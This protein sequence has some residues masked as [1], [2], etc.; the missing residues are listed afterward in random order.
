MH[1][2]CK[3][4][5]EV[6]DE[7]KMRRKGPFL[8]FLQLFFPHFFF[9]LLFSHIH[10]MSVQLNRRPALLVVVCFISF[11]I[12]SHF[13]TTPSSSGI[14]VSDHHHASLDL[15]SS[16]HKEVGGHGERF[17]SQKYHCIEYIYIVH[18]CRAAS[19]SMCLCHEDLQR[20]QQSLL[21]V[22]LLL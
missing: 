5:G 10:V 11:A 12:L 8:G 19:G 17:I 21:G 4:R 3:K 7:R 2:I 16:H 9:H 1:A 20:I 14:E 22:L 18:S 6:V 13:I 15:L